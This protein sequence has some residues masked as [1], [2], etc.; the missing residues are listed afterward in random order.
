VAYV[1]LIP[2]A[3]QSSLVSVAQRSVRVLLVDDDQ[4]FLASL[5][6]LLEGEPQI[7]VV[8]SAESGE[9]AVEIALGLRPDVITMDLEMPGIGGIEATRLLG[10]LL[11]ATKV[12]V[13]SGSPTAERAA[14]AREAGASAYLSKSRS[15]E[16]L[17]ATLLAV[18]Y[19]ENFVLVE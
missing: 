2:S 19:G 18:A 14:Q 17:A 7:E 6:A 13:V 16:E 12:L 10:E 4:G 5:A 11:P 1:L 15:A 8:G 3:G 9:R